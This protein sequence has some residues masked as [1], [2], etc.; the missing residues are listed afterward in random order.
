MARLYQGQLQTRIFRNAHCIHL[1]LLVQN[2]GWIVFIFKSVFN[3]WPK[4]MEHLFF[5]IV[6]ASLNLSSLGLLLLFIGVE[7]E[8]ENVRISAAIVL[9][10]KQS[11]IKI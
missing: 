6:F 3:I 4:K 9:S 8:L 11:A 7:L 1:I 2:T 10:E 5:I